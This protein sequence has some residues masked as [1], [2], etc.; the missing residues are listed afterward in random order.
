MFCTWILGRLLTLLDMM[1]YYKSYGML[2]SVETYGYGLGSTLVPG[3]NVCLLMVLCLNFWML[4]LES[5][6]G[7]F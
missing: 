3:N 5:H 4:H 2:V 6:R 7:V 1:F